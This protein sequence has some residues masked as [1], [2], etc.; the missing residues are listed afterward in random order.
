MAA[1]HPTIPEGPVFGT[2]R[3]DYVT[4]KGAVAHSEFPAREWPSVREAMERGHRIAAQHHV[5]TY[6]L[7]LEIVRAREGD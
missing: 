2:L 6:A 3:I 5:G 7:E 4:A 1:L